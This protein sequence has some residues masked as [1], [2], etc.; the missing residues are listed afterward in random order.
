MLKTIEIACFSLE[1]ALIAQAAGASRIEFCIDK[2]QGGISPDFALMKAVR[3]VIHIPLYM[4]IRPRGGNF[5][6]NK[7]EFEQMKKMILWAKELGINGFVFGILNSD[8]TLNVAENQALVQLA[9]PLPCTFHRAFDGILD[10]KTALNQLIDC[11]F[12]CLL[13][14]GGEGNAISFLPELSALIK[15]AE[16][17]LIVM[18]GGGIRSSNIAQIQAKTNAKAIHSAGIICG[19]LPDEA[20]I[21]QLIALHSA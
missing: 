3:A 20:E 10:K 9:A 11:G 17:Q 4:M 6:Y 2:S 7:M 16:N 21:K 12:Q 18:P 14:A 13:T 19:D 5:V 8:N 15:Q 1:A